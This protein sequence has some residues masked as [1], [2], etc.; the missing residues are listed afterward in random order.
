MKNYNPIA[1]GSYVRE[2]RT[3]LRD[4]CTWGKMTEEEK[5]FFK[6]CYN[7]KTYNKYLAD[8]TATVCPCET[9][10]N[11]KTEIQVDNRMK[12]LRRKYLQGGI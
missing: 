9:C 5:Q 11:R 7:C 6:P 1:D 12:A 10:E 3:I 4:L 2:H 8:E